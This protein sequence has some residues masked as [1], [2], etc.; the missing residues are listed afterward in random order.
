[1]YVL[2][3]YLWECEMM[4]LFFLI[5]ALPFI[6]ALLR[7]STDWS[8][9]IFV[10]TSTSPSPSFCFI[11]RLPSDTQAFKSAKCIRKISKNKFKKNPPHFPHIINKQTNDSTKQKCEFLSATNYIRCKWALYASTWCC[12][13]VHKNNLN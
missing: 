1:M 11:N 8:W 12:S 7:T 5:C 3:L 13:N 10:A 9:S 2:T 6:L 4:K